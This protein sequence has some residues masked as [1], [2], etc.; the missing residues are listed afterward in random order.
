MVKHTFPKFLLFATIFVSLV[1]HFMI[2]NS[3]LTLNDI[4]VLSSLFLAILLYVG[5]NMTTWK[6][7]AGRATPGGHQKRSA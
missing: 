4:M 7:Q 3:R 5:S 2:T 6:R 1:V